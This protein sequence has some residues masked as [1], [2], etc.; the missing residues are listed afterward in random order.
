[1]ANSFIADSSFFAKQRYIA[2]QFA[3]Q[4]SRPT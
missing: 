2:L 1:M 4:C 3:G